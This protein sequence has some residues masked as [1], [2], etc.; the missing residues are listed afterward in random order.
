[1]STITVMTITRIR[2]TF[3][4]VSAAAAL[5]APAASQA[6]PN[7]HGFGSSIEA[8]HLQNASLCGDLLDLY[9]L[10]KA[11]QKAAVDA[12]D[13][14]TSGKQVD[15]MARDRTQAKKEGCAWAWT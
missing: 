2:T 8:T 5:A 7:T 15:A 13:Y 1:M 6:S 4:L 10:D 9:N 14:V 3:A 11:A 12:N